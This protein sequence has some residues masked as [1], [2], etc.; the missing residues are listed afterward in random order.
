MF[1]KRGADYIIICS[2]EDEVKMKKVYDLIIPLGCK[3]KCAYNLRRLGLQFESF[4]FDWIYI[5]TP[6]V[7]EKLFVSDF[8]NFMLEENLRLRS[9]QP[10]FDEV[11]DLGTGIYSAHDFDT[12]KSISEV[13]PDVK[14]KFDRR[15]EKVKNKIKDAKQILM[16]HVSEDV[17]Q[18]N[19]EI[20][21]QYMALQK[22]FSDKNLDLLYLYLPTEHV[23][24][25]EEVLHPNVK[26]ITFFRDREYEW[27]G[28]P[29]VFNKAFSGIKLSW[30][31]KFKWYT[32]E[33]YISGLRKRLFQ[34]LLRALSGFIF[35]KKYRKM[36]RDKFVHKMSKFK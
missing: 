12:N 29:S 24:Y 14:K 6:A 7:V 18:D 8:S 31:T 20:V 3:C 23:E 30:K 33:V 17:V 10:R 26:K 9:K 25:S 35:I 13:Y 21:E 32:S 22:F 28:E 15:I 2:F 1:D 34:I 11:D 36:F 5:Q 19:D 27:Q 16:V 4:P